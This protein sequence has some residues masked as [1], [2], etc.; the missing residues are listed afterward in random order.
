M[1]KAVIKVKDIAEEYAKSVPLHAV[2]ARKAVNEMIKLLRITPEKVG[3]TKVLTEEQANQVRVELSLPAELQLK[4]AR[5]KCIHAAKNPNYV[6]AKVDGYD[7]KHPV[8]LPRR[9]GGKIAPGKFFTVE[10]I[11]DAKGVTFRHEWFH[12]TRASR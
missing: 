6:F 7:G 3:A 2:A 12:K 1:E 10:V 9:Y 5:A 4:F 11:E 8:L